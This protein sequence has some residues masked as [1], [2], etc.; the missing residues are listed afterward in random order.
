MEEGESTSI[1]QNCFLPCC[2]D[3]VLLIL[4]FLDHRSLCRLA[5][6]DRYLRSGKTEFVWQSL[7]KKRW[8]CADSVLKIN[9]AKTWRRAYEIFH[10]RQRIPRGVYTQKDNVVFGK[11]RSKSVDTWLLLGHTVDARLNRRG[12]IE[13]RVCI[14]SWDSYHPTQISLDENSFELNC[15]TEFK[16]KTHLPVHRYYSFSISIIFLS[17]LTPTGLYILP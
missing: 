15:F 13:V 7:C 4:T 8:R 9:G 17:E 1:T 5:V 14:Q 12:C 11:G 6:V 16:T 2:E 3:V 10:V